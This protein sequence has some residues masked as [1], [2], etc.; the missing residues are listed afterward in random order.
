MAA[1]VR[2]MAAAVRQRDAV[3]KESNAVIQ[4][5]DALR[6]A[7]L[8]EAEQLAAIF[9][10]IVLHLRA[11]LWFIAEVA[12]LVCASA[13]PQVHALR[14][15]LAQRTRQMEQRRQE[16]D[17]AA[18][19]VIELLEQRADARG[20]RNILAWQL[21][22]ARGRYHDLDALFLSV[23][24]RAEHENSSSLPPTPPSSDGPSISTVA[25][26]SDPFASQGTTLHSGASHDRPLKRWW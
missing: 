7:A 1:A 21:Q 6:K 16:R 4:E 13:N 19:E 20:A 23:L 24:D 9:L 5:R 8:R 25:S 14:A 12:R 2:K 17:Q 22:E 15:A 26:P 18:V 10:S 3:V 11:V